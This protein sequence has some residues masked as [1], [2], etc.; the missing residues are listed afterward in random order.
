MSHQDP[1]LWVPQHVSLLDH[2]LSDIC[3]E[4]ESLVALSH[5]ILWVM[6]L[7]IW[8][9][10]QRARPWVLIF[11]TSYWYW[12]GKPCAC[13]SCNSKLL[14]WARMS[15]C[16]FIA[17]CPHLQ[18]SWDLEINPSDGTSLHNPW[19]LSSMLDVKPGHATCQ[20]AEVENILESLDSILCWLNF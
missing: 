8:Q 6:P 4:S 7:V 14:S 9:Q 2:C 1:L 18:T 13:V 16:P 10:G 19:E 3:I 20:K 15:D 12:H 5:I 11:L 17:R